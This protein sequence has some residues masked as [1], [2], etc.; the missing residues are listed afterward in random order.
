MKKVKALLQGRGPVWSVAPGDTVLRA[1]EVLAEKG[2]GALLVMEGE[3]LVGI[4]SERD[5]ARKI[6]L[7][8]KTSL[9]TRVADIMVEDVLYVT[10]EQTTDDCMALMSSKRIRHLPV[11]EQRKVVGM[12]SIGDLVKN[13]LEEQ[14][15]TIEQL[16]QYIRGS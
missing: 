13:L 12:L 16:E 3:N 5:Y 15:N 10:P 6:A 9:E 4:I 11:L 2:V 7:R 14:K 1:L 8:G